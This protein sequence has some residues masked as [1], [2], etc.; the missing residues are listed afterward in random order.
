MTEMDPE[1]EFS[2]AINLESIREKPCE[3]SLEANQDERAALSRR[4]G[5][6]SLDSLTAKLSLKWLDQGRLLSVSGQI[7]GDVQ[8]SCVV[9]L[10]PVRATV[11]EDVEIV[12]A[13][14][15]VDKED[16]EHPNEVEP[17][18]G[19]TLDVGEIVAEEML[20]ALDPYPRHPQI[21]PEALKLGPGACLI[22]EEEALSA[23][24]KTNPFADLAEFLP[25][26]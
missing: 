14:G 2:V 20:L 21:S 26:S 16:T 10:D 23:E 15:S 11:T 22:A 9:T 6:I 8:Q 19:Q 4:F 24:R 17:L 13:R 1:P 18:D 5:L 25:K 12:F 3:M 7:T